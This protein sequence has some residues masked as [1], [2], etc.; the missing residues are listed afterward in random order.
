MSSDRLT[1]RRDE[2][3]CIENARSHGA[4]SLR[5]RWGAWMLALATLSSGGCVGMTAQLLNVI[6]GGP[7]V[8]AEFAGLRAKRVAVVC[9]SNGSVYGLSSAERMLERQV[10]SIL[11]QN[12][13]DIDVIAQDEVIDWIDS[14]DWDQS[15]YR[16]IGR[17]VK[18]DMVLAI[19]LAD[20]RLHQGRTLYRGQADVVVTV[21]DM[22]DG[23]GIAFRKE[24]H[25]YTFPR[26]G[27]RP[28][29]EMSEG[30][31]RH[32]FVGI[33]AHEIAKYFYDYHLEDDFATDAMSLGV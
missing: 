11:Q 21:Y 30:R 23:G 6:R 24:I 33:L 20:F 5:V 8:K 17:G 28:T 22:A 1:E 18:A 27:P 19:D 14:H 13:K 10:A 3:G 15:D 32:L 9:I 2:R 16:E 7:K 29:T 12:V 31:F 4:A 26:N 25:D